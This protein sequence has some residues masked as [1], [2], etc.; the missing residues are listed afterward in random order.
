MTRFGRCLAVGLCVLFVSP[1]AAEEQA[2]MD[3]F[4]LLV[5]EREVVSE[6][7]LTAPQRASWQRM[8]D[9]LDQQFFPLRNKPAREAGEG[10]ARIVQSL[11]EE[12]AKT[13]KPEQRQ[14]LDQLLMR[15]LGTQG[16]LRPAAAETL[17]LTDQQLSDLKTAINEAN[18]AQARL[19]EQQSK[20]SGGEASA[21]KAAVQRL[22][23]EQEERQAI[24]K[25]LTKAQIQKLPD[26]V[27]ADF[28]LARFGHPMF[29]APELISTPES[30]ENGSP[31]KLNQLQGQV[32]V[33]HFFANGC[34]NCIHNYPIYR[35]WHERFSGKG[36]TLVGVHTPET[37]AEHDRGRLVLK[38]KEEDLRFPVLVDNERAN[39]NAWGNSMWPSVYVLDKRGYLRYFWPGEL[40]WR[41][42]N[43][44]ERLAAW[45]EELLA[46]D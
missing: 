25:I 33:V 16:L 43:G 40:N 1:L 9:R 44:E 22:A 13:L 20:E 17:G 31:L 30:W 38:L 12:L 6:L 39:W 7:K 10:Q 8:M 11:H 35:R 45:I 18:A 36:V 21:D 24:Q 23:I 4:W 34:I 29:K 46:E 5:H 28:D 19:N 26:L 41:G 3:P 2:A 37:E 15:M 27:A 14:R 42:Q 32:L